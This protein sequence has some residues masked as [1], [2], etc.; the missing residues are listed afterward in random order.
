MGNILKD[1]MYYMASFFL[2][3]QPLSSILFVS[4][5]GLILL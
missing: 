3:S 2:V 4:E 1:V 5:S